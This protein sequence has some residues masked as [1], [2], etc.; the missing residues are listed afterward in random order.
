MEAKLD[1]MSNMGME[2]HFHVVTWSGR[3]TVSRIIQQ[4]PVMQT[5]VSH[6]HW[7]DNSHGLNA[8]IYQDTIKSNNTYQHMTLIKTSQTKTMFIFLHENLYMASFNPV[9]T[10]L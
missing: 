9:I 3:M 2:M 10:I 4:I 1:K 5:D 7:F 8:F 6:R